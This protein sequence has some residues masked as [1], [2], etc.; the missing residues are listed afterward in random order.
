MI[1]ME[2]QYLPMIGQGIL[3]FANMMFSKRPEYKIPSA[4]NQATTL[5]GMQASGN[6]PG[7]NQASTNIGTATGNAL[8]AARESGNP[9]SLISAIQGNQNSALNKLDSQNAMYQDQ[10]Q[11][12]FQKAL[13]QQG[14]FQDR[15]FQLNEFSPY[16]DKQREA[17]Q[18]FGAGMSSLFS[19][20]SNANDTEMYQ[21]LIKGLNGDSDINAKLS[22]N[23]KNGLTMTPEMLKMLFSMLKH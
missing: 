20:M 4:V 11:G 15:K 22:D 3:G 8:S 5:A 1:P 6:M 18:M 16:A 12:D 21:K 13:M 7:Y 14:E 2:L 23:G 9:T 19:A 17:R 10:K